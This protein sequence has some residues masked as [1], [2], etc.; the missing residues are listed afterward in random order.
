MGMIAVVNY[1]SVGVESSSLPPDE[2]DNGSEITDLPPRVGL[3]LDQIRNTQPHPRCLRDEYPTPLVWQA[4]Y[5]QR[6]NVG[7]VVAWLADT[8]YSARISR[9]SFDLFKIS[10]KRSDPAVTGVD[11]LP[12]GDGIWDGIFPFDF[13]EQA[14]NRLSMVLDRSGYPILAWVNFVYGPYYRNHLRVRRWDGQSWVNLGGVLNLD[15]RASA[16]KPQ[17]QWEEDDSLTIS[18]TEETRHRAVWTGQ[19]WVLE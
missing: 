5:V 16:S 4:Y 14:L 7:C 1:S 12:L 8:G 9:H 10:V 18:W 15:L 6:H 17:L 11:W 19:E 2:V 3:T 13:D